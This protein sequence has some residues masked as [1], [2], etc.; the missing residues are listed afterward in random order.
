MLGRRVRGCATHDPSE[1]SSQTSAWR[2]PRVDV[3][4]RVDSGAPS[5]LRAAKKAYSVECHHIP[6]LASLD[7]DSLDGGF[8]C[9]GCKT[10][11][12]NGLSAESAPRCADQLSL[13]H[14]YIR[15]AG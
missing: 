2:G 11:Q 1:L 7:I 5:V 14:S 8:G 10:K 12:K 13:Q 15:L 3:A 6:G 4:F 9:R